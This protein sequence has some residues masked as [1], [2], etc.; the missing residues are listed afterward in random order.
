MGWSAGRRVDQPCGGQI[1]QCPARKVT[2]IWRDMR[3]CTR[4]ELIRTQLKSVNVSVSFGEFNSENKQSACEF[5]VAR[6]IWRPLNL[7]LIKSKSFYHARG[8]LCLS[9]S[10]SGRRLL[11]LLLHLQQ[12][13][14]PRCCSSFSLCIAKQKGDEC[15]QRTRALKKNN[16][17]EHQK[18][19]TH[20]KLLRNCKQ[21]CKKP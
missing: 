14:G 16:Y 11:Q 17:K 19:L 3:A 2:Q 12:L 7:R 5:S 6:V 9:I 18:T 13:S 1:S 4:E 8:A 15:G 10:S 20:S 21:R